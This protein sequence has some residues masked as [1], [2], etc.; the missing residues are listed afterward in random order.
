MGCSALLNRESELPR[1]VAQLREAFGRHV[2]EPDWIQ[3]VR[4]LSGSSE[5]LTTG[6][7]HRPLPAVSWRSSVAQFGTTTRLRPDPSEAIIRNLVPSREMSKS[8]S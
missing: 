2:G 5:Q 1:M 3:F 7:G 8:R 6:E 4:R